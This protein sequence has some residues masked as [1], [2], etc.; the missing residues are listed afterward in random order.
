METVAFEVNNQVVSKWRKYTGCITSH[1]SVENCVY[2][3]TLIQNS[4]KAETYKEGADG[5]EQNALC[6]Q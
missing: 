6:E 5:P 4:K 1:G 3:N 2:L